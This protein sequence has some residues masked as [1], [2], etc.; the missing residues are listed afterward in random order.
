MASYLRKARESFNESKTESPHLA[1][2]LDKLIK[3]ADEIEKLI[4]GEH[5]EEVNLTEI[6]D[7]KTGKIKWK[8]REYLEELIAKNAVSPDG[9]WSEMPHATVDGYAA[10][11]HRCGLTDRIKVECHYEYRVRD[12]S[13][14]N[15]LITISKN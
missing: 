10:K 9:K 11:I 4:N 5:V 12:L 7:L 14:V 13:L 6:L 1:K 8:A 3:E 2:K 15:E